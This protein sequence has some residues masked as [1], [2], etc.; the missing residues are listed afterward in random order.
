MKY[1]VTGAP[2]REPLHVEEAKLHLR[3]VPGD[4]AEDALLIAPLITAAR[5]YCENATGLALVPQN[6]IAYP[7]TWGLWRLPRPPVLSVT[8]IAWHDAGG[9]RHCLNE[10]A[11]QVDQAEGL[12]LV[13]KPP[14]GGLRTGLNPIEVRY[15][16]GGAVPKTVRQAMLLLVGHWYQNREAVNVDLAKSLRVASSNDMEISYSVQRLLAQH[17][18]WW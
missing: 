11:Y 18:R 17:R 13:E 7:E 8:E 5:E 14:A 15:R 1:I 10:E 9:R 12:L 2:D 4:N 6:I 3:T 16:A